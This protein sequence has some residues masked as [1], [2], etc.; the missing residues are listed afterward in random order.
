MFPQTINTDATNA[1]A[2]ITT[3]SPKKTTYVTFQCVSPFASSVAFCD[4]DDISDVWFVV[5]IIIIIASAASVIGVC[6]AVIVRIV[7]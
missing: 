6:V 1:A 2:D 5:V 3:V 7:S 4:K